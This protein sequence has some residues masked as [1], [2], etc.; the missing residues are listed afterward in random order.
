MK[1]ISNML[2]SPLSKQPT[3]FSICNTNVTIFIICSCK[4][5]LTCHLFLFSFLLSPT[6]RDLSRPCK[7]CNIP[8]H[9]TPLIQCPVNLDYAPKWFHI[10]E[11]TG[12]LPILLTSSCMGIGCLAPSGK[13]AMHKPPYRNTSEIVSNS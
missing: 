13:M 12:S 4:W 5:T 1:K 7:L 9:V 11:T 10:S 3:Y 2:P 6:M 8:T